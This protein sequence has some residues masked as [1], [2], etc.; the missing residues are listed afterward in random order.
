M[1]KGKVVFTG[2]ETEFMQHYGLSE[3]VA[4]NALPDTDEIVREL[5]FL[6]HNRNEITAISRRARNFIES[7][8][9]YIL[10]AKK[11]VDAWKSA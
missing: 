4:V 2:A 5:E 6:I 8:H 7:E 9:N 11:Y 3:R 1:A 10:I